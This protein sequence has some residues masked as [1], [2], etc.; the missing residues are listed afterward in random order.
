MKKTRAFYSIHAKL[1]ACIALCLIFTIPAFSQSPVIKDNLASVLLDSTNPQPP[2]ITVT[3]NTTPSPG[4]IFLANF[5]WGYGD[6]DPHLLIL[7]N[8]GSIIQKKYLP[9]TTGTG[10]RMQMNG[11]LSYYSESEQKYYILD[12]NLNT[13]KTVGSTNGYQTD[14]HEL[15][16]L[17][18]GNYIL[19]ALT[20]RQQ[21]MSPIT[22]GGSELATIVGNIIQEYDENGNLIF[23]WLTDQHFKITDVAHVDLTTDR[24]DYCHVNAV[25]VDHDGNLLI[26]SRHLDEITKINRATG[27]IIWRWGG[28]NNQFTFINDTLGFSHQ[29]SVRVLPNGNYILFDNGNYH[30]PPASRVCEYSI[31]AS[32]MTATL[33][34]EF[35]HSPNLYSLAMGSVQYLDNGNW[36]IGWGSNSNVA[37]TEVTPS[38]ETVLEMSMT[39]GDVSYRAF[40]FPWQKPLSSVNESGN[41]NYN[42]V[43]YPTPSSSSIN[44]EYELPSPEMVA[45]SITDCLG[46]IVRNENE[47]ISA[48][49]KNTHTMNMSTLPN[50]VYQCVLSTQKQKAVIK[51]IKH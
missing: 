29:H 19:I 20:H 46:R 7:N 1:I 39:N 17:P 38:G 31:D 43:C 15:L 51:I 28:K 2:A 48:S 21:D 5:G 32:K 47:I 11:T 35:R 33:V 22:P 40:K 8:D 23:E 18:N 6:A 12:S 9:G 14:N 3:V 30:T 49:G 45:I 24:I 41:N 13:L 37:V 4:A 42:V 27:E 34:R 26:S 50:G 16:Y 36:L 10:F 44:I 25:D